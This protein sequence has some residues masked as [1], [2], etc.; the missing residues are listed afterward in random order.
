MQKAP[1]SDE[2]IPGGKFALVLGLLCIL[3]IGG[4]VA[5]AAWDTKHRN[6]IESTEIVVMPDEGDAKAFFPLPSDLKVGKV[7]SKMDGRPLYLSNVGAVSHPDEEVL[8]IGIEDLR[9]H[10]IYQLRTPPEEGPNYL[11]LRISPGSYLRVRDRL[12]DD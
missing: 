12:G 2:P 3:L 11:L 10:P 4:A 9:M 6:L 1:D 5:A 8:A 7:A